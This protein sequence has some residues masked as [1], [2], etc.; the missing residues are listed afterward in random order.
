MS[1]SL[2]LQRKLLDHFLGVTPFTAPAARHASVHT[3]D[4]GETGASEGNMVRQ[5]VTTF[6]AA[7]AASPSVSNP[8]GTITWTNNSGATIVVTHLGLFDAATAGNFLVGGP[9]SASQSVP[10]GAQLVV[11]AADFDVTLD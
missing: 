3:A 4:P 7:S 5:A 6:G 11:A 1:L 10:A 8:A 9:L 2:Y